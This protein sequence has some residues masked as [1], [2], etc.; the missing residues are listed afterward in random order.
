MNSTVTEMKTKLEGIN[1][2]ETEAERISELEDRVVEII[3]T[4]QRKKNEKK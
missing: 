2:R 3:T 4:E 1:S